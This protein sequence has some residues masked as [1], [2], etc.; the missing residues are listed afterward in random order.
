MDQLAV[1]CWRTSQ[2][3]TPRLSDSI[4]VSLHHT[5][6]IA[7]GCAAGI[8]NDLIL[9]SW[10]LLTKLISR[11]AEQPDMTE[12][13]NYEWSD[14]VSS[15]MDCHHQQLNRRIQNSRRI[16]MVHLTLV[17]IWWPH[18]G[19]S[20]VGVIFVEKR[21]RGHHFILSICI[22]EHTK[23]NQWLLQTPPRPTLSNRRQNWPRRVMIVEDSFSK[24]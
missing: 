24:I 8:T 20:S 9:H 17:A 10:L 18:A 12:D 16:V 14:L 19:G 15:S 23:A 4:F 21:I 13:W 11:C 2:W 7:Q 1:T 22:Y 5:N 6:D 3:P